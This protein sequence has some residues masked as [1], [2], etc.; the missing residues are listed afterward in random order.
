MADVLTMPQIYIQ[1]MNWMFRGSNVPNQFTSVYAGQLI[2]TEYQMLMSMMREQRQKYELSYYDYTVTEDVQLFTLPTKCFQRISL[3]PYD[4]TNDYPS[5]DPLTV[6]NTADSLRRWTRGYLLLTGRKIQIEGCKGET[7]RLYY[8][9]SVANLSCGIATAATDTTLTLSAT[10]T[11]DT[12]DSSQPNLGTLKGMGET[13]RRDDEYNDEQLM[14]VSAATNGER[15]IVTV[16]D[17]DGS[18]RKVTHAG[19]PEGTPTAGLEGEDPIIYSFIPLIPSEFHPLLAYAI[20]IGCSD[21]TYRQMATE[22]YV[23]LLQRFQQWLGS[24]DESSPH[25]VLESRHS[26]ENQYGGMSPIPGSARHLGLN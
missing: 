15:Q 4:A 8:E 6:I 9:S 23:R 21:L 12:V 20:P 17:Y 13:S 19:W 22:S 26:L 18:L 24:E 16:T 11:S 3:V 25:R 14:I 1:A 7:V 2:N 5:D 10:P